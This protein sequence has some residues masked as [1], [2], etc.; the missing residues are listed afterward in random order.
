[1]GGERE[2]GGR[3][4]RIESVLTGCQS[5]L[6]GDEDASLPVSLGWHQ[7]VRGLFI[8][9]YLTLRYKS[10]PSRCLN[11]HGPQSRGQEPWL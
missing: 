11:S 1:M 5:D 7:F 10:M 3:G 6:T 8:S 2:E 4:I 9:K